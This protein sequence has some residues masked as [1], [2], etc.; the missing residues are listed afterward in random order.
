MTRIA[1][2]LACLTLALATLGGCATAKKDTTGFAVSRELVVDQ[3]FD[4]AWLN[5]KDTLVAQDLTVYTRDKRGFFEAFQGP[6]NPLPYVRNRRMKYTV[7]LFP[8]SRT[9]TRIVVEAMKQVYGTS[10]RTY[11]DWHDRKTDDSEMLE[12]LLTEIQN[13]AD[14]ILPEEPMTDEAEEEMVEEEVEVEE[15]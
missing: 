3:P 7:D 13:R 15:V 1:L 12:I 6:D 2:S 11:P 10:L 8:V 14:G 9:E 5:V 4:E